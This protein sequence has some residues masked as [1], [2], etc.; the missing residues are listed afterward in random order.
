MPMNIKRTIKI[1]GLLTI[2]AIAAFY[3]INNFEE[4]KPIFSI[5][6]SILT[7]L[8]IL[9]LST[10]IL[11]GLRLKILTDRLNLKLQPRTCLGIAVLQSFLNYLPLKGGMLANAIYLKKSH[12]FSYMNFISMMGSSV[13][14]TVLSVGT[15]G[16]IVSSFSCVQ[17]EIDI[18]LPFVFF[19]LIAAA[20]FFIFFSSGKNISKGI[21]SKLTPLIEGWQMI[22]GKQYTLLFLIM[23]DCISALII[24]LRYYIAFRAFSLN[25]SFWY[26]LMI[27]PLSILTTFA[28]ITPAGL[29]IR[30][31]T[32]GY[33][34]KIL[35][36]GLNQGVLASS[37]DR[38]VVM[39]WLFVLG[40][41]LSHFIITQD[42]Y[43][44]AEKAIK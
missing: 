41:I 3:F 8:S 32:V 2:G 35:G 14:I 31:A 42:G 17:K 30:E 11:N 22:R 7:L 12:N 28:S 5:N 4:I 44:K 21:F 43:Q 26:C 29:G 18:I 6:I 13:L 38:A 37:L 10:Q 20:V 1:I 23:L 15:L 25:I 33:F 27:A 36:M 9:V 24:S 16:F 40:P 19:S 34:S 39:F